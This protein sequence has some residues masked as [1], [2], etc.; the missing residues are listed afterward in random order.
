MPAVAASRETLPGRAAVPGRDAEGV[1]SVPEGAGGIGVGDLSLPL[2]VL[3][4]LRAVVVAAV[5][6]AQGRLPL[7]RG[8][9]IEDGLEPRRARSRSGSRGASGRDRC[10]RSRR[11]RRPGRPEV[12]RIVHPGCARL[13]H[14]DVELGFAL[15]AMSR[16]RTGASAANSG[17]DRAGPERDD[18]A[19]V[20]A[21]LRPRS[22][23]RSI[24]PAL[25]VSRIARR[26]EGPGDVILDEEPVGDASAG[27]S[28]PPV[29]PGDGAS[30]APRRFQEGVAQGA[31]HRLRRAAPARDAIALPGVDGPEPPAETASAPATDPETRT[32]SASHRGDDISP[33]PDA[34]RATSSSFPP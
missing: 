25:P 11:G 30:D 6:V 8:V 24:S 32:A 23:R 5:R 26:S 19:Q 7:A 13:R 27:P 16:R 28:R 12:V 34:C 9:E 17:A 3:V 20:P 14:A 31:R 15:L 1:R 33:W 21:N 10:R 22:A 18:T 4:D 29:D 2:E